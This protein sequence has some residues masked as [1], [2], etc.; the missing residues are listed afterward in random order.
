MN[1][2]SDP[3]SRYRFAEFEFYSKTGE[4]CSQGRS[5]HLPDQ[6]AKILGAL[7]IAQGELV[8][9]DELKEIL[10]PDKAYG[11]LEGGLNAAVRK[12]R[13]ALTDDGAEPRLIGTLPKRGYR[14]L[15]TV[16][17]V[18]GSAPTTVTGAPMALTQEREIPRMESSS[19]S[20]LETD[21]S[22]HRAPWRLVLFVTIL[23]MAALA[24]ILSF[25]SS[26]LPIGRTP[27]EKWIDQVS[28]IEF[29][30]VPPGTF[31]MG[32]PPGEKGRNTDENQHQVT[33]SKGFWVGRYEVT[34]G[35][36]VAVMGTNPSHFKEVGLRAPVECVSWEDTQVFLQKL[37]ARVS[38]RSYRLPTE[39]E[40][41][42]T[43]RAGSTGSA[44]G[45]LGAIAWNAYTSDLKTHPVGQ[46]LP[47]AWGLYDMIG[48]V[49]EW[50]QDCYKD[51]YDLSLDTD[52][53]GPP[54]NKYHAI[55]GGS[56]QSGTTQSR[57]AL[58]ASEKMFE[59]K[60]PFMGFRVVCIPPTE[61]Q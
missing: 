36:Y 6:V 41:E 47:N 55:R 3:N 35:Q 44:Y 24:G 59:L 33:I 4:I 2:S 42:Y 31:L 46:K 30:W 28:G 5:Q 14:L 16:E 51:P 13:Q 52:P 25:R 23:A 22:T 54:N 50:C 19:G 38:Y 10:W 53:V 49:Y 9:R 61:K 17:Q 12:L 48:N 34:Q 60:Y 8:T 18:D 43:C 7:L 37:N 11:D 20:V 57:A 56:W 29:A 26:S 40:W 39:A 45:P 21:D 15:V 1:P 58:R 32:S 27:G